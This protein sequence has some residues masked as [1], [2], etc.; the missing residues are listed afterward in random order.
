MTHVVPRLTVGGDVVLTGRGLH[1]GVPCSVRIRASG[2]GIHFISGGEA[3]EAKAENV[4]DTARCTRLGH[5]STVEHC[6]SALWGLGVTDAVVEVEGSELPGLDGSA[7][8]YVEALLATGF[9]G[10][11]E[12]H[13]D[14]PFSRVYHVDGNVK[15]AMAAGE[16]RWRYTYDLGERWPGEQ[17]FEALLTSESYATEVA[18]AR[19]IVLEEEIELAR[20]AGLGQ[21]LD[22]GGVVAIGTAGYLTDVRFPDEP[23]RHKLLDLIG[24]LALSGV[25]AAVLNVTADRSGHRT[26]VEAAAKLARHVRVRRVP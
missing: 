26:N 3:V 6:L 18:P 5:V 15:L 20:R 21:G 17:S 9:Y 14:G 13:I 22:E 12:L 25:P 23:A 16:S 2:H 19:T 4:T 10:V 11:G 8:P 24:D 7:R 1:S